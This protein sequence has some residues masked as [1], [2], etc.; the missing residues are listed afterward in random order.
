MANRATEAVAL[1]KH[2]DFVRGCLW[3][4]F[5]VSIALAIF[6]YWTAEIHFEGRDRDAYTK[7]YFIALAGVIFS[8]IS[9]CLRR[10]I[11]QKI[12]MTLI[13][14]VVALYISELGLHFTVW[15]RPASRAITATEQG[16]DFDKR[17]KLE[18][19]K[20][21]GTNGVDAVPCVPGSF[22]VQN[23]IAVAGESRIV[24]SGLSKTVTVCSNESGKRSIYRTDRYGFNNP[25]HV[26]NQPKT[27]A[28][29]LGDSFTIGTSVDATQN[30]ASRLMQLTGKSVINLGVTGSSSLTSLATLK[31]YGI[32]KH[33]ENV[34]WVYF[35]GNDLAE[36]NT[37]ML[38]PALMQYLHKNH[39][40]NLIEYQVEIDKRLK[41]LISR[42]KDG[43]RIRDKDQ[44]E[45]ISFRIKQ[46]ILLENI[47]SATGFDNIGKK[48]NDFSMEIRLFGKILQQS[49][50]LVNSWN[51]DF[52]FVYLPT[53]G[54]YT[55]FL[56]NHGNYLQRENVLDM[57]RELN[58]PVIDI[59]EQVFTNH[60]DPR[61]LFPL[62]IHGHYNA[63]GYR[64]VA[65][66]IAN[67]LR[68]DGLFQ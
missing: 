28:I 54:R 53:Y 48:T 8:L 65:E 40:N 46:F 24:F 43:G 29:L 50:Q 52:Y 2:F 37:E 12:I 11:Q 36:L 57:A 6:T 1:P 27:D 47:R 17:T 68:E 23:P 15:S 30:I 49:K 31:E 26:W 61:S 42:H 39:S 32:I 14:V 63:E 62:R 16:I 66:A 56:T 13:S 44:T 9:F 64:L 38:Y 7:F 10:T 19:I 22:L 18:V 33:P 41:K 21:L 45:V 67:R 4:I 51:G 34:F 35:E 60:S 5:I 58:I 59:H 20:D 3:L 25:D 55:N